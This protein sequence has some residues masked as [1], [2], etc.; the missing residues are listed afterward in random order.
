VTTDADERPAER[1]VV[2]G[3]AGATAARGKRVVGDD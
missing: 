2:V 3:A 1:V